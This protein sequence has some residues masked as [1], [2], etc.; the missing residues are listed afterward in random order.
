MEYQE[1]GGGAEQAGEPFR[2]LQESDVE[3]LK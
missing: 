1:G 2:C 3:C